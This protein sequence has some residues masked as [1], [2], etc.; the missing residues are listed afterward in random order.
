MYNA[1]RQGG[2]RWLM[3]AEPLSQELPEVSLKS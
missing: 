2:N 3:T 1:K